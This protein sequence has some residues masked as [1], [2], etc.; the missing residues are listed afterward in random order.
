MSRLQKRRPVLMRS[1]SIYFVEL[2][3]IE[4]RCYCYQRDAV[5]KSDISHNYDHTIYPFATQDLICPTSLVTFSLAVV[6]TIASYK[7]GVGKST[8][9]IGVGR[10][11]AGDRPFSGALISSL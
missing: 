5:G 1:L 8:A 6:L 9:A 3:R 7:G 4:H 11:I 2:D 10:G